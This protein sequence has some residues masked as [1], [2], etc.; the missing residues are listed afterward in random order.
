MPASVLI[1]LRI[2]GAEI[3]ENP[4]GHA[5]VHSRLVNDTTPA[6]PPPHTNAPPLS[7]LHVSTPF[8]YLAQIILKRKKI[9][10]HN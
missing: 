9:T 3:F 5:L 8:P 1:N 6:N 7:P 2:L 10:N 4:A